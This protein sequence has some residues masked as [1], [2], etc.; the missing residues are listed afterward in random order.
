MPT[1]GMTFVELLAIL[2]VVAVYYKIVC[3]VINE[4]RKSTKWKV[5]STSN[6]G[7]RR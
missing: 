2:P 6:N 1:G 3:L 4:S 7:P 5:A